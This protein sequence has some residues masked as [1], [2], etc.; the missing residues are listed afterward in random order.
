[1]SKCLYCQ[2]RDAVGTLD[3]AV[4]EGGNFSYDVLGLERSRGYLCAHIS[5]VIAGGSDILSYY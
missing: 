5:N 1:M 3:N 4:L 2:R